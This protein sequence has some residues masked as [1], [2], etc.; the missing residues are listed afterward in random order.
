MG[1]LGTK[2]LPAYVSI[3]SIVS[4]AIL[5]AKSLFHFKLSLIFQDLPGA[6]FL[7][8]TENNL[9][10]FLCYAF[11]QASANNDPQILYIIKAM[12][13]L[14]Q[15]VISRSDATRLTT[16]LHHLVGR[17]TCPI[18]LYVKQCVLPHE[19]PPLPRSLHFPALGPSSVADG[20]SPGEPSCL[21][22]E[23]CLEMLPWEKE[24]SL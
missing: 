4:R 12:D 17:A 13:L 24:A 19:N 22:F 11:D 3:P 16:C 15:K 7:I 14:L 20:I 21:L 10:C 6:D 8:V 1:R 9:C 18:R 23:I 5:L 2:Q